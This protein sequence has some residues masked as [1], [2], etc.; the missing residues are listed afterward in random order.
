MGSLLRLLKRFQH[1]AF[2]ILLESVAVAV[3]LE[4]DYLL[5]A[6]AGFWL[7]ELEA[8]VEEQMT[9]LSS[10]L[11]LHDQ[12]RQLVAENLALR[13][14][15]ASQRLAVAHLP[16][17]VL[18]TLRGVQY[19]YHAGTVVS[20]TIVS[21]HNYFTIDLGNNTDIRPE[22]PVLAGGCVAGIVT[23]TSAHYAVAISV[24]NT[25]FRMS[26]KLQRTGYYGSLRWDGGDYRSVLLSDIPHHVEVRKGDT[27]VTTG[28]SNIFPPDLYVG[29]VEGVEVT[30]GDFNTVRVTLGCDF[31]RLH[32]VT[33]IGDCLKGERDSLVKTS[34]HGGKQEF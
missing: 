7:K 17:V 4:S 23:T 14:A 5:K 6:R 3:Y 28:Y 1:L 13:N 18:D 27:V 24:L 20:N 12:N 32:E 25:D 16:E 19:A 9:D 34:P 21:P 11:W 33:I 22:M 30:G 15:L 31:K 29:V 10:Y 2:F 8:L 26:A